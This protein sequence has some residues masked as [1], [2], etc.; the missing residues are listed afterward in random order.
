MR[1]SLKL[2][3]LAIALGMLAL[4]ASP[5]FADSPHFLKA[6]ASLASNGDLVVSWREAGLGNN[7]VINY[8]ASADATGVYACINGGGKH[9]KAANKETVSG[10]VSAGGS[11]SSGKNGAIRGSLTLAPPGP[12]SFSCPG[13]Q[14]LVLASVSYSNVQIMDQTNSI[15]RAILGTFSKT[16][17]A[18]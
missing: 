18:L 2:K 15:T 3:G 8:L 12:G 4:V 9:P 11:F 7:Q 1:I 5:A 13:G 16:F 17:F 10:P 14:T 6:S